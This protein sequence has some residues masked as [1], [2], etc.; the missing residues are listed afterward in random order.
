MPAR[1]SVTLIACFLLLLIAGQGEAATGTNGSPAGE[2]GASWGTGCPSAAVSPQ[3]YRPGP[4]LPPQPSPLPVPPWV[5]PS[6]QP[7]PY[8]LPGFPRPGPVSPPSRFFPPNLLPRPG[9]PPTGGLGPVL[10]LP[11]R[12]HPGVIIIDDPK[13]YPAYPPIYRTLPV[14]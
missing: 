12:G 5:R 4:A 11:P 14:R 8:P 13:P 2:G 7:G 6:P 1:A 3:M 10:P 9:Q